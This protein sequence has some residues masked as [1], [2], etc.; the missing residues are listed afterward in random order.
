MGLEVRPT[1]LPTGLLKEARIEGLVGVQ[2]VG[3]P[4]QAPVALSCAQHFVELAQDLLPLI[5]IGMEALGLGASLG[6]NPPPPDR[7]QGACQAAAHAS[8]KRASKRSDSGEHRE[9]KWLGLRWQLG[10][11]TS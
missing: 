3:N 8:A 10:E 6:P 7:V 11:A 2:S 9:K 5:G 4:R 1:G